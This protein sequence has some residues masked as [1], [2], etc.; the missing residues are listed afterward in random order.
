MI[1][2]IDPCIVLLNETHLT[3]DINDSEIK[4]KGYNIIRTNSESRH[5]GGTCIYIKNTIEITNIKKNFLSGI[6]ITSFEIKINNNYTQIASIY[7][8]PSEDKI[9]RIKKFEEW[10]ENN[11]ENKSVV[12]C[13]DFNIDLLKNNNCC[14]FLNNVI[15]DNGM[16]Q[17]INEP[18]RVNNNSSTLIDLCITNINRI[19]AKVSIDDQISDHRIIQIEIEGQIMTNKIENKRIKIWQNYSAKKFTK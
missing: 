6:W 1:K 3:N 9:V 7:C 19:S 17:I 16:K 8:S 5:T 12:L 2:K 14:R 18:T 4:I 13:G 11:C 15:N 10:I